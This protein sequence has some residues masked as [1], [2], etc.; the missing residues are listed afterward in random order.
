MFLWFPIC[1]QM[2]RISIYMGHR[3]WINGQPTSRERRHW[4]GRETVVHSNIA[5]CLHRMW[6]CKECNAPNI[7]AL[8]KML[9]TVEQESVTQGKWV[10]MVY[11]GFWSSPSAWED[12][13]RWS[14]CQKYDEAPDDSMMLVAMLITQEAKTKTSSPASK[15]HKFDTL[16][17]TNFHTS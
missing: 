14:E 6:K 15:L 7:C 8:H 13:W 17:P 1:G 3:Q 16:P 2:S 10:A 11:Q 12:E 9:N 5:Y 4:T